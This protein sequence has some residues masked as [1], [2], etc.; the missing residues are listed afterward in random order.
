M[1]L[2][3]LL[4]TRV[5]SQHSRLPIWGP[6]G[7]SLDPVMVRQLFPAGPPHFF[8][9]SLLIFT[10]SNYRIQNV[11][12]TPGECKILSPSTLLLTAPFQNVAVAPRGSIF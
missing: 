7:E 3:A 8:H 12:L 2:I 5:D 9:S 11:A 4:R 10:F 6:S 1:T